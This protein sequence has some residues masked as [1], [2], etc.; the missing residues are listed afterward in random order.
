MIFQK[1]CRMLS[2]TVCAPRYQRR[3]ICSATMSCKNSRSPPPLLPSSL[4]SLCCAAAPLSPRRWAV[5]GTLFLPSSYHQRQASSRVLPGSSKL[6]S[7]RPC[8]P[9]PPREGPDVASSA[10]T[11]PIGA[12][13]AVRGC[14]SPSC[15][16]TRLSM[17]LADHRQGCVQDAQPPLP[18]LRA[19]LSSDRASA[20]MPDVSRSSH[21][22]RMRTKTPSLR[23]KEDTTV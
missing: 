2:L 5:A 15:V 9:Q 1:L 7:G 17:R 19:G 22:R 23:M 4:I 12:T 21:T 16:L 6:S 11:E 8:D 13:C 3:C 20:A 14:P 18:Q 10:G